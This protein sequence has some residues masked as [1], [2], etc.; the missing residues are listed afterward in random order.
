MQYG[1]KIFI[2]KQLDEDE[3]LIVKEVLDSLDLEEYLE[4]S[5]L[6]VS[7]FNLG[8]VEVIT[9][10]DEY[11]YLISKEYNIDNKM[12]MEYLKDKNIIEQK[13]NKF[14][15]W[16]DINDIKKYVP[17]ILDDGLNIEYA[18]INVYSKSVSEAIK[19]LDQF[20]IDD[21]IYL[22]DVDE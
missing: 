13:L 6:Y 17:V 11:V 8:G 20:S 9:V 12:S 1:K 18:D 21:Y 14:L 10:K 16:N 22:E 4:H 2:N 7:L 5:F 19:T 3:F 15:Y